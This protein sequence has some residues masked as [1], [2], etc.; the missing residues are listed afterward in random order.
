MSGTSKQNRLKVILDPVNQNQNPR[1]EVRVTNLGNGQDY[2]I[3]ID[4]F[5]DY[6]GT[7]SFIMKSKAE[8]DAENLQQIQDVDGNVLRFNSINEQPTNSYQSDREH[9]HE[10]AINTQQPTRDAN[11]NLTTLQWQITFNEIVKDFT[12]SDLE[13]TTS[14]TTTNNITLN[15]LE[16]APTNIYNVTATNIPQGYSGNITLIVSLG[17]DAEDL[18]GNILLPNGIRSVQNINTGV[19]E[20]NRV[21]RTTPTNEN[22][23]GMEFVVW[24]IEFSEPANNVSDNGSD[25]TI[26]GNPA[27]GTQPTLTVTKV[28]NTNTYNIT[29][30]AINNYEGIITLQLN[31]SNDIE[32][33][34]TPTRTLPA[35][36]NLSQFENTFTIDTRAPT[37]TRFR[38]KTPNNNNNVVIASS[39]EW[40][41]TFSEDIG[42][43]LTRD[44]LMIAE[45]P[46]ANITIV[47][48]STTTKTINVSQLNH[49]GTITLQ[50]RNNH[51]IRDA[52]GTTQLGNRLD[53]TYRFTNDNT[54]RIGTGSILRLDRIAPTPNINA[55]NATTVNWEI[56]FNNPVEMMPEDLELIGINGEQ[57]ILNPISGHHTTYTIMATGYGEIDQTIEL[58]IVGNG[59]TNTN[60]TPIVGDLPQNTN[61]FI[62]DHHRPTI[63]EI[64]RENPQ[65][66]R[67]T[68]G[69]AQ[70]QWAIVFSEPITG[71]V[72]TDITITNIPDATIAN[73]PTFT[74][75]L[76]LVGNPNN[77]RWIA[78]LDNIPDQY[79]GRVN[80][81]INA[82]GHR[83]I[84]GAGNTM[85]ENFPQP[86]INENTFDIVN[87]IASVT[88]EEAQN[89]IAT[90]ITTKA[91]QML[92]AEPNLNPE[93]ELSVNI[94]DHSYNLRLAYHNEYYIKEYNKIWTSANI[95]YTKNNNRKSNSNIINFG[96]DHI[97]DKLTNTGIIM[98]IDSTT[99][100]GVENG[101][102]YEIVGAGWMFGPYIRIDKIIG[103]IYIDARAAY[104]GS[105]NK[106]KFNED[107]V[108]EFNTERFMIKSKIEGKIKLNDWTLNPYITAQGFM[109]KQ[110]GFSNVDQTHIPK[111]NYIL[112]RIAIGPKFYKEYI[113]EPAYITS[114]ID[115]AAIHQEENLKNK[116]FGSQRTSNTIVQVKPSVNIQSQ[117][118]TSMSIQGFSNV[119][120]RDDDKTYGIQLDINL[121]F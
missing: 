98:Q 97:Y 58:G 77:P 10:T 29:T 60:G 114:A 86:R 106:V 27:F 63:A 65:R 69:P 24:N 95:I 107:P 103:D 102:Q 32:E 4:R 41:V 116:T 91:K 9:P 57:I 79:I 31:S 96:Y 45:V 67:I 66:E 100:T 49:Q 43:S 84:D 110:K 105:Q 52:T 6:D 40:E 25:F 85:I 51:D 22:A 82:T 92:T 54:F 99:D 42:N 89:I 8:L 47:N 81:T 80:I 83:I 23:K 38:R 3:E 30:S 115:I 112:S 101:N 13:I 5:D 46:N 108:E 87:Q 1:I 73:N 34:A 64:R 44:D 109:E 59:I 12:E 55:G 36:T 16:T 113:F 74:H 75:N 18:A 20:I 53:T 70:L 35:N 28:T 72:E 94:Y 15:V 48:D 19:F 17:T 88:Q 93:N 56:E 118:G 50:L 68:K 120:S 117:N 76:T 11:G 121:P 26:T 78:T 71:F 111:Q 90:Y 119:Y 7:I 37:V 104:G 33:D 2:T 39:V 61:T 21:T 62:L 14:A